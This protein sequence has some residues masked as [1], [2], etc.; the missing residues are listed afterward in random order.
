MQDQT[1]WKK[2]WNEGHTPWDLGRPH[3]ATRYLVSEALG[4][5]GESLLDKKVVIPGGGRAHDG[6]IFLERG[7]EVTTVDLS[8][9]ACSEAVK[10]YGAN[11]KFKAVS[12]NFF[13]FAKKETYDIVFDRAMLCALPSDLRPTYINAASKCLDVNGLFLTIPF[14]RFKQDIEGPPFVIDEKEIFE[15][16]SQDFDLVF[17]ER[18]KFESGVGLIEDEFIYAFRKK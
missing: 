8:E 18:S 17:A 16:F 13:E 4:L 2:F 9:V 3:A 1:D 10:L 5:L 12:G 7:A 14:A 15:L 11:E 6:R